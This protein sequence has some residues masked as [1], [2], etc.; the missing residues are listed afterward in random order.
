MKYIIANW[1]MYLTPSESAKLA[2]SLVSNIRSSAR[3]GSRVKLV[4]CPS[5]DSLEIVGKIIK[6]SPFVLGAQDVF[7]QEQGAYTGEE[8]VKSLKE[9]GSKYIIVG[10]SER[11]YNFGETNEM[12]A[13]K[14]RAVLG[15]GL[16][17][18]L[19]IG[20]TRAEHD[21]DKRN[22]V[23]E[24]QLVS[25]LSEI[26]NLKLKIIDLLVAYEPVWAIGT[27]TPE[28]PENARDAH[29]FIR[30]LLN[31]KFANLNKHTRVIYGGSVNF[32]NISGF[33][34]YS[35]IDG[36]L[37]GGASTKLG[38]FVNIIRNSFIK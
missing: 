28:T 23:L 29:K 18:I 12:V 21:A 17:P 1:K 15:V 24:R 31:K 6:K 25:A 13:K 8:S 9:L 36:A 27:G 22:Q 34:K 14:F 30:D 19:C 26:R 7:W 5:F 10:H 38:E 11:R 33:L 3:G 37:I 2:R 35:E 32:K 16:T 4:I 20:E